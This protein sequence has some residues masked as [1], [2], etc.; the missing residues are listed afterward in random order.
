MSENNFDNQNIPILCNRAV[1]LGN[2]FPFNEDYFKEYSLR[3]KLIYGKIN[4]NSQI[5]IE[6]QKQNNFLK[7]S[8]K[9]LRQIK[10]I[11][12]LD[13]LIFNNSSKHMFKNCVPIYK[14]KNRSIYKL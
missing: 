13:Y 10:R 1:F 12:N 2:G 7:N 3:S 5:K 9:Y 14:D 8:P 11:R 6:I 4:K